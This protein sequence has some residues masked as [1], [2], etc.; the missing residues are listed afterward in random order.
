MY[1]P[2]KDTQKLKDLIDDEFKVK[3][4][5]RWPYVQSFLKEL[6]K[7][8]LKEIFNFG[9]KNGTYDPRLSMN[10]LENELRKIKDSEL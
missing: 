8:I 1:K 7:D 5:I 4:Y 9:Y 6:R 3:G 2:D 10:Y